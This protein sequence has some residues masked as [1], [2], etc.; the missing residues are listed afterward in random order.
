MISCLGLLLTFPSYSQSCSPDTDPPTPICDVGLEFPLSISGP[1][2][3]TIWATD[4]DGGS[5]DL[6]TPTNQL[7]FRIEV[8]NTPSANPPADISHTFTTVGLHPVVIWVGDASG[9]WNNCTSFV[10][11]TDD[12][13]YFDTLAPI[14]I[15]DENLIYTNLSN[16]EVTVSY[17]LFDDGSYDNFPGPLDYRIEGPP[18]SQDPPTTTELTFNTT[19]TYPIFLWVGDQA[20]NWDICTSTLVVTAHDCQNDTISPVAVCDAGLTVELGADGPGQTVL[21]ASDV[22]DGSW[23]L[24]SP[25]TLTIE[26]DSLSQEPPSTPAVVLTEPG[27]FIAILWVTDTSG[28]SN[29]CWAQLSVIEPLEC[30][31]WFIRGNVFKDSEILN[32][33]LDPQ[34][35]GMESWDVE[36]RSLTTGRVY[37]TLTDSAG[38]Y[39]LG[40]CAQDTLIE[41]YLDQPYNYSENCQGIDTLH[42]Q[43]P[44]Y[45]YGD[46]ISH[47]I[48]VRLVNYCPL[49]SIDVS[50]PILRRCLVSNKYYVQAC[51]LSTDTVPDVFAEVHF[52]SWF[53]PITNSHSGFPLGSN[54]LQFSLGDLP[55]GHCELIT[56][57]GS[58]SCNAEFGETHCTEAYIFPDTLCFEGGVW[59]GADVRVNAQCDGDSVRLQIRNEGP[60]NMTESL[61]FIVVED[62]IMYQGGQFMLD[63]DGETE[64]TVPANGSTWH[65]QADQATGHPY[66]GPEAIAV[67]GC[68]GINTMGVLNQFPVGS[69]NPFNSIFCMQ[70]VGSFDPNDKQAFPEGYGPEH[71]IEPGT[72]IRYKIR[73]QNTGTDTAFLVEILDTLS[74]LLDAS[75]VRPGA[76]SHPYSFQ[77]LDGGVL[78]FRF[79]NIMLPDSNVNEPE[80]HGFV[81][82]QIDQMDDNPLGPVIENSAAIYFDFNEPVITN[83]TFHTL[84][85]HFITVSWNDPDLQNQVKV[86]PNPATDFVLFE[87]KESR[88]EIFTLYNSIG[89]LVDRSTPEAETL[90]FERKGLQ[91]GQYLFTISLA[92]GK[93]LAGTLILH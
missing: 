91:A 83:T 22:D 65:L 18:P 4:L 17:E 40:L 35:E 81:Q 24:C 41:V 45:G 64:I 2:F 72:S 46:T 93:Q 75:S 29:T 26:L 28:N 63:A 69:P 71:F 36:V 47:N 50:A 23:D 60:G 76:S 68:G 74:P 11:I 86:Y 62:V 16:G 25:V 85:D 27:N 10:E 5:F 58:L 73:F 38:N 42:L 56:I 31:D 9:N 15:C 21:W 52:D 88:I 19:G 20:G 44:M 82:F 51:N 78:R 43:S 33:S 3:T 34:E 14:A 84:G 92:N 13:P 54:G 77:L 79:D 8:G 39:F 37:N 32:C 59:Q 66:G 1:G 90:R 61:D 6:C 48:P 49:L 55:P 87:S 89:Q 80:S 30:E 53:T 57:T 67:E 7:E 70:N 12:P